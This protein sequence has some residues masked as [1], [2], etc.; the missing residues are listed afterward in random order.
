MI[1]IV[2]ATGFREL[3]HGTAASCVASIRATG[4][5][6]RTPPRHRGYWAMLTTSREDAEGNAHRHPQGDQAVITYRVPES[7]TDDFLYPPMPMG[8]VTWYMLRRPLPGS[9]IHKVDV[10]E[11]T[12]DPCLAD[13]RASA[14]FLPPSG[15]STV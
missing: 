11:G 3:Y 1:G 14:S 7:Q 4:L 12:A 5:F 15:S 6:P 2:N 10:L 9:M 8:P 13:R